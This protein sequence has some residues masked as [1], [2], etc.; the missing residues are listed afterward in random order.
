MKKISVIIPVYAAEKYIAATLQSVLEQT[1]KNFEVIIVDDGSP[2]RSIEICRQFTDSRIKIIHQENRGLAGAR[3]TGIRHAKGEY[4]ALID[5][6]DLWLPEKLEKHIEH[7]DKS[8]DVGVSF[9][10]SAFINEVGQPLGTYHLPKLSGIT[11][12]YLLCHDPVGNGSA[13]VYRREV[14]ESIKFQ[15]NIHGFVEDFYFEERFRMSQDMELLLR[16]ALQTPWQIEGIPEAL[17]LYR[18]IDGTLSCNW[19]KKIEAWEKVI[20]RVSSYAPELMAQRANQSRAYQMRHL[21]RRAVRLQA[22]GV[23]AVKLIN[24]ALAT[25]WRILVEEPRPTFMTF[26]AAYLLW[27]LPPSAY[28]NIE[29]VVAKITGTLQRRYILESPSRSTT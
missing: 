14:F 1:Y 20:E 12:P 6:D 21:A 17:T 2:D 13:G 7:L 24:R 5:A 22:E 29:K 4:L 15:D 16:I 8:P 27:L 9:S 18:V 26:V 11:P 25:H 28:T 3:N 10:L 23:V 19:F